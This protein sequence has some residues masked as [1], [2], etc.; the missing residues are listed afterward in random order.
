MPELSDPSPA[1]VEKE[2]QK[3]H[4]EIDIFG[5]RQSDFRNNDYIQLLIWLEERFEEEDLRLLDL[6]PS[7]ESL[8]QIPDNEAS[9]NTKYDERRQKLDRLL[10]FKDNIPKNDKKK[11]HPNEQER[12][13]SALLAALESLI[14]DVDRTIDTMY[15]KKY[16]VEKRTKITYQ[17]YNC[18]ETVVLR[19]KDD[20]S[21]Y[22]CHGRI[23][24]KIRR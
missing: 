3:T 23:L 5:V 20:V 18:E 19:D 12:Q 15:Y 21:C 7:L 1:L 6:P 11:Q 13:D 14:E 10:D 9:R 8:L 24:K 17:C 4:Q 16:E 2:I 22:W